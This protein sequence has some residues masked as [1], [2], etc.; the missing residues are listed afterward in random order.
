MQQ[1]LLC[2]RTSLVLTQGIQGH[3]A[4]TKTWERG[5]TL[6]RTGLGHVPQEGWPRTRHGPLLQ[7]SHP[8]A[9]STGAEGEPLLELY[10]IHGTLMDSLMP[11]AHSAVE[12]VL[13]ALP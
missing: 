1:C 11:P 8:V 5:Q 7:P 13:E 10:S 12:V 6:R 2:T 4:N 3:L 9:F